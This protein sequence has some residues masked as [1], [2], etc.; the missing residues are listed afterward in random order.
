MGWAAFWR[1]APIRA[2]TASMRLV[3][4]GLTLVLAAAVLGGCGE[5]GNTPAAGLP[6]DA[7][8]RPDARERVDHPCSHGEVARCIE[9]CRTGDPQACN[10]AG[11]MFE[12]DEG[13]RSEPQLA[14]GFYTRACDGN[15][16]PGCNNLAWLYL[17]GRG[18]PQDQ[19]RAMLL[20]LAAFDSSKLACLR[21][22]ASGCL[23]AGELLYEGRG[24][25][26]DD[27]LALWF[28]RRACDGGQA[29]A[30]AMLGGDE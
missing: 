21:G 14:A 27:R 3:G 8:A 9:R 2:H 19:P 11:V 16:G 25:K 1:E 12:F 20:F 10:A 23:L 4:W 22:D 15:Y 29:R 18:V 6:P 5:L 24:V 26:E 30:C 13:E 17:R 7:H 28:I